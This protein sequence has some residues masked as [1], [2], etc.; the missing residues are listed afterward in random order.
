MPSFRRYL[1]V[2]AVGILAVGGLN[3]ATGSAAAS[4]AACQNG[5]NGFVSIPYNKTGTPIGSTRVDAGLAVSAR[6]AQIHVANIGGVQHGWAIIQGRTQPGD[7]V[8]MDWTRDNEASWIQCG[9]FT[10]QSAGSPNTSAAK[11]TDPSA[12]Y[13]FRACLNV[14]G[15]SWCGRWW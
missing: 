10:V 12:S 1:H 4:P 9:P 7:K 3:L 8:W 11:R 5:A 15:Q 13:K 2:A 14:N 6:W